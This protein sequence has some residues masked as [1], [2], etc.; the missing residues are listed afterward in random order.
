M[1]SQSLLREYVTCNKL[2]HTGNDKEFLLIG[3]E[4]LS[5][6]NTGRMRTSLMYSV[7]G[8]V[9]GSHAN[10]SWIKVVSFQRNCGATSVEEYNSIILVSSD[11]IM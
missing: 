7:S 8:D 9:L 1:R 10:P 5:V 6:I 3:V 4:V 2:T 11:L